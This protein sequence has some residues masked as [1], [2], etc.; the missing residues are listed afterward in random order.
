MAF[1]LLS[2]VLGLALAVYLVLHAG[3]I[4]IMALLAVAG[5]SLL[6]LVPFH[7]LPL[8]LDTLSWKWLL[9]SESRARFGLLLWVAL[10]RESVNSLLPVAR[11]GGELLGIRLLAQH[12]LS[13]YVAGA[14]IM[15]EVTLTLLSQVLFTLLG[16]V[17]LMVALTNHLLV[18]EVL[19]VLFLS[20][21]VL[22]VFYWL[23]KHKGLFCLLQLIGKKL[24][25]G[26]DLLGNITDPTLLDA[27]IR[28]LYGRGWSLLVANFWQLSSFLAGTAEVWVTFQLLHHP[29]PFWAALL[30]ESLGQALRSAAFLVPGGIGVQEGGFVL[31]GSFM[32]IGPDLALAYALARRLREL[33]LGIP[34]LLSWSIS[35]GHY[36]R[37]RWLRIPSGE[38]G[39]S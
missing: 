11:V 22:G 24:L 17:V 14:S 10:V 3:L 29:I 33:F 7:L 25:G 4:G 36:M 23:Q 13:P 1:I 27:E 19:G 38:E 6:W 39:V 34:V 28:T 32:G 20:L 31:L 15:V 26:Y 21:P 12:G 30:L 18:L 2:G 5:W 37:R 16:I 9:S 8:A 35:E